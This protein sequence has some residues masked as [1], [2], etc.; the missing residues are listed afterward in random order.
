MWEGVLYAIQL[1]CLWIIIYWVIKDERAGGKAETGFLAAHKNIT[2]ARMLKKRNY[3]G[4]V[5]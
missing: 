2:V 4:K 1:C 3:S 5:S